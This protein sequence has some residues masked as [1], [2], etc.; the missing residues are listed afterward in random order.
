MICSSCGTE[1]RV[2]AK[3][4]T[5]CAARLAVSCP[6]CGAANP[7]GAR[8]CEECATALGSA[9]PRAVP[10]GA[11]PPTAERRLVS[12]LFADLVGFTSFAEGR[13]AEEVRETLTAYFDLATEIVGRYGGTVEKFIGDAVMAVWGTPTAHEDDAE[14]AVRAALDLVDGVGALGVRAGLDLLVRAGILTGEAA[15]TIGATNQ[16]MV[17]GD[18]VNTASR[19]QSIA[20]P[21]S[22]LVGDATRQA[23]GAAIA[24][25]PVGASALKGKSL[26]VP[27]FRALRVVAER[28]GSG[29][30]DLLEPPFVGRTDELRLLKEQFHATGRERRARLVSLVGQ[31][32][33]GKSRLAWELEKY[34]DGVVEPVWWH[35]GRSPAYGEGVTFWALGEMIRRRAGLAEGDDEPTTRAAVATM[36]AR[37]IPDADERRWI[38]PRLFTLLGLEGTPPGG[39][40]EL[41]AAWRTLFERIAADGTV[42]LVFED[43][44]WSDDG[45]LDFIEHL[46]D[47][48]GAHPI[49]VVT[50]A[51]PEL[52]DRRPGWGTDRRGAIAMRLEPLH[53]TSMRELLAALV[54]GLPEIATAR[55][56]ARADGIPLYLVE[57]VRMLVADG[58]LALGDGVYRPMA[59]LGD[60]DVPATLHALVAARLDALPA[61]DRVLVQDAAVLGQSFTVA[62]LAAVTGEDVATLAQ[63]LAAL[64]RR[65]LLVIETDPRAPTRGQYAFVQALLREVAYGTL[66][67]RERRS[68]HLAAARY[69]ESLEDD[70]L[71]GALATHYF[72][73]YRAAPDGP[74]GEAA[75]AQARVSLRAAADRA[76]ALGALG[77]AI[78]WLRAAV[79][80]APGP[81]E[82][83]ELLQ[84]MGGI[85][86]LATRFDD[87]E[88]TL[89]AAAGASRDLG[90]RAAALHATALLA[91]TQLSAARISRALATV[92]AAR[93]EAEA[94]A[95]EPSAA[96]AVAVFSEV[97]ARAAF[98]SEGDAVAVE[99]SDRALALAE[100]RRLDEVVAMA[101]I[102][103]G[104]SLVNLGRYREGIAIL[105][106]AYLDARAHS[107]HVAA[108]RAGV[109]LAALQMDVDPRTSLE[110]TKDGIATARRYGFSA[111]ASYHAGNL[112]GAQRTGDW[113]FIHKAAA[114]LARTIRDEPTIQWVNDMGSWQGAW[115]GEDLRGRPEA[116]IRKA[117]EAGDPQGLVNGCVWALEAAFAGEDYPAAVAYGL[118][119]L[120]HAFANPNARFWVGR[121]ALHAGDRTIVDRVLATLEPSL[122][123]ACDADLAALRAG[124]AA[125]DGRSDEAVADYRSA[126]AAYRDLGL[127]FDVA[128]TALDMAAL[129][130]PE[131]SAVRAAVAEARPILVELGATPV[132]ARLDRLVPPA[133]ERPD[134]ATAAT[135][136]ST[137]STVPA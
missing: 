128:I 33:I 35:R 25:E 55:I 120:E 17:A 97:Y 129:V 38:E 6:A 132:V 78:D 80:V 64:A 109:N 54:P 74:E 65:E 59:D 67:K 75:A 107:L 32:G 130:G 11:P 85:E 86:A 121:A 49:F 57:T 127:R 111:F 124:R 117:E 13:D 90:D 118:R 135:T 79:D 89:A 40:Q 46:L 3:F 108:L 112:F 41:F 61:P 98:R 36:L 1:N 23:A 137:A 91:Q 115:R 34:L 96:V 73:A 50:L 39:R 2:G 99:W 28:R 18:L 21:G 72:A 82:R 22:V 5:E 48:S 88:Q 29:R 16:G 136:G 12:I 76:E 133:E 58:R 110:W 51:R 19:L 27:A 102:T 9:D 94:L 95:D 66:A 31:A 71:A 114:E 56:L 92:E 69:F 77:Q 8:F 42:A 60:L 81:A 24:F 37:H 131:E 106:G 119:L 87:A 104:S 20:P 7:P 62:A 43:L 26:A 116:L 70:E 63:R 126:L 125:L 10:E 83:A 4:C 44:Q 123:G 15:V 45:L 122:G 100:P 103:K 84:R 105:N 53:E 14:R 134:A 52:L 30:S 47:W 101:L 68:R 93:G 113:S